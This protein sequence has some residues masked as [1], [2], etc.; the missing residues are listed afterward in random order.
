MQ[1]PD[2]THNRER[3]RFEIRLDGEVVGKTYYREDAVRR[4]F[5]HTEVDPA[6]QGKGLATRLI[7]FAL[8]DTRDANLRI[9]AECPS[10][11]AFLARHHEYDDI[12]DAVE[13]PE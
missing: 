12:V 7:E 6:H 8:A 13:P 1:S 11:S 10:V 4:L 3:A 2:F 5:T 9:S